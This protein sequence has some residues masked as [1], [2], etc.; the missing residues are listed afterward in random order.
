MAAFNTVSLFGLPIVS[1]SQQEAIAGML[2]AP[3]E[4]R[5][6]AFLNAHCM[7]THRDDASYRWA[8]SKADYLLPD[9]AGMKL[10]ARLQNKSFEANL[11]GTDLFVPLCREA[12]R[13]GRSIFFF[14]SQGW[15]SGSCGKTMHPSSRPA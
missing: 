4:K 2:A 13:R 5:T 8:I 1:A 6:A 3:Q 9:G 14:G 11:N 7:N 15:R 10:A 12:A